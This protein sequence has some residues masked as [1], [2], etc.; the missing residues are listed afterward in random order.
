M[1]TEVQAHTGAWE[2]H[3]WVQTVSKDFPSLNLLADS[4]GVKVRGLSACPVRVRVLPLMSSFCRSSVG[5][6]L[7]E[8]SLQTCL[9]PAWRWSFAALL[10]ILRL[11]QFPAPSSQVFLEP[12][13]GWYKR[14]FTTVHSII[15]YSQY[16]LQLLVSVFNR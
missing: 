8:R 2:G 13:S 7:L 14:L 12:E 10:P 9:C 6:E 16:L 15:T 1:T 4:S 5:T 3:Q 11:A